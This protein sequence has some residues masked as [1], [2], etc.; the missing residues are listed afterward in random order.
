MRSAVGDRKSSDPVDGQGRV[1]QF[2]LTRFGNLIKLVRAGGVDFLKVLLLQ[3]WA[4]AS[5]LVRLVDVQVW[6]FMDSGGS[7]LHYSVIHPAREHIQMT[8]AASGYEIGGCYTVPTARGRGLYPMVL[9][10]IR[11]SLDADRPLYMIAA[12][13]NLASISG[14]GKA[15]LAQ[16]AR[17]R[18]VS[19]GFRPPC[20]EPV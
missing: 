19:R 12:A 7:V 9:G 3:S 4:A 2:G 11:R 17:L 20:Y 1:R 10:R 13:S 6:V 5:G 8:E 16:V 15:G 18:R 14:M